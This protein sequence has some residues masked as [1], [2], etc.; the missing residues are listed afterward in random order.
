M[1]S[2]NSICVHFVAL[3]V[4]TLHITKKFDPEGPCKQNWNPIISVDMTCCIGL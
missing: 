3:S 4:G 1:R 2:G